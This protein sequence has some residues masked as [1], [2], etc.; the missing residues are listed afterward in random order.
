L[1][2]IFGG[3]KSSLHVCATEEECALGPGPFRGSSSPFLGL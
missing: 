2:Q 1:K 3:A